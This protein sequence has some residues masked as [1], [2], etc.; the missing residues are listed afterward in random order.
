VKKLNKNKKA[1]SKREIKPTTINRELAFLRIVFNRLIDRDVLAKN[2]VSR[3]KFLPENNE[4]MRVLS[5]KEIKV[6]IMAC[7]QPLRDVA[8][9]MLETGMRPPEVCNL[10]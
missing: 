8:T 4:Q 9:V 3:F 2:P 7:S 5:E 6:N 1:Q 10:K